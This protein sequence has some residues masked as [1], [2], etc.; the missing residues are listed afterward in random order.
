MGEK[1]FGSLI[2]LTSVAA[3]VCGVVGLSSGMLMTLPTDEG[4]G[5]D[6]DNDAPTVP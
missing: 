1:C 4:G 2:I 3:K 6:D 5:D